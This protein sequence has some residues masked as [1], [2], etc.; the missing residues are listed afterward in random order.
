VTG[1]RLEKQ[2]GQHT[3]NKEMDTASRVCSIFV[4]FC[5][6]AVLI[7][8]VYLRTANSRVFYQVCAVSAQQDRLKQELW[9]KQLLLESMINPA[10]VS[11]RLD[12]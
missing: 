4:I 10:A 8:T 12:Y 1:G 2:E 3:R 7:L 6:T 9:E 5:F 11:Q